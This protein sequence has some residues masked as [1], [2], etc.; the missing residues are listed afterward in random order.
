MK[1]NEL[2]KEMIKQAGLA[3]HASSATAGVVEK[4]GRANFVTAADLKS[5][6]ILVEAI[7]HYFPDDDIL[8][9]ETVS[10]LVNP[11]ESPRLWIIDP[12]DGTNNFRFSRNYSSISVGYAEKGVVVLAGAY[13][14]FRDELFYAEKGKGA[15]LNGIPIQVGK[16]TQLSRAVVATDNSY[17]PKGTKENLHL[18]LKIEPTPW[19]LMKGAAVSTMCEVACG[20]IDMYFQTVLKPWDLAAAMLIVEEAGGK[21]TDHEGKRAAFMSPRVAVANAIL[22][23]Q[24]VQAIKG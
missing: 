13:D 24:F 12:I 22:I 5:E 21:V 15:F 8:S 10:T 14:P 6:K 20:R 9:E 4:E 7:K 19:V 17:D 18:V 3:V 23:D 11:L 1:R 2:L 16:E